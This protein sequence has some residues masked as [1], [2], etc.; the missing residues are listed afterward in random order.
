MPS[1]ITLDSYSESLQPICATKPT[2][3]ANGGARVSL[4]DA[5]LGLLEPSSSTSWECPYTRRTY[6][7]SQISWIMTANESEGIPAPLLDRCRVFH[8]SYPGPKDLA[9]LIRKQSEGRIYDEVMG[10][11]ITRVEAALANG[12]PPSLR[13]IQQ[14]ID[15]AAAVAQDPVLH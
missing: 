4:P 8:I 7:M 12:H 9:D 13:R 11:L 15:E 10:C 5:L 14:L 1:V 3:T 6:N 2:M